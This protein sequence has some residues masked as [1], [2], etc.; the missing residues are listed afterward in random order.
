MIYIINKDVNDK[1]EFY[2]NYYVDNRDINNIKYYDEQLRLINKK[3]YHIFNIKNSVIKTEFQQDGNQVGG[4]GRKKKEESSNVPVTPTDQLFSGE[5]SDLWKLIK[6]MLRFSSIPLFV[7]NTITGKI[8]NNEILLEILMDEN[9]ILKWGEKYYSFKNIGDDDVSREKKLGEIIGQ[10]NYGAGNDQQKA[11]FAENKN[12][13]CLNF[14]CLRFARFNDKTVKQRQ[15]C[16]SCANF[17]TSNGGSSQP[18]GYQ[19]IKETERIG[20]IEIICIKA[21]ARKVMEAYT[22]MCHNNFNPEYWKGKDGIVK[23]KK[24]NNRTINEVNEL[25]DPKTGQIVDIGG[26]PY[27]FEYSKPLFKRQRRW[28]MV[29]K[30]ET[31][32]SKTNPNPKQILKQ[33]YTQWKKFVYERVKAEITVNGKPYR[34]ELRNP[35]D[36]Y[37]KG[38]IELDHKDGNHGDNVIGNINPLCRICHAI[39]TDQQQDKAGGKGE[40]FKMI[41]LFQ[42]KFDVKNRNNYLLM[43]FKNRIDH[44]KNI[45]YTIKTEEDEKGK[46]IQVIQPNYENI[47]KQFIGFKKAYNLLEEEFNKI[48]DKCL[49]IGAKFSKLKLD[50]D[51]KEVEE[52]PIWTEEQENI[53]PNLEEEILGDLVVDDEDEDEEGNEGNKGDKGD[54]EDEDDKSISTQNKIIANNLNNDNKAIRDVIEEGLPRKG[55]SRIKETE[56]ETIKAALDASAISA[57][58]ETRRRSREG[59]AKREPLPEPELTPKELAAD[60][61]PDEDPDEDED[62][63]EDPDKEAKEE[64]SN[65]LTEIT[66]YL[67]KDK[68]E[69]FL[70]QLKKEKPKLYEDL[71]N[72]KDKMIFKNSNNEYLSYNMDAEGP[73]TIKNIL[74]LRDF[75]ISKILEKITIFLNVNG[76]NNKFMKRL[77][78]K[79]NELY[80]KLR[81]GD[82]AYIFKN[83][84]TKLFFVKNM[85]GEKKREYN[86]DDFESINNI[87][88]VFETYKDSI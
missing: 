51:V 70:K 31:R 38:V 78:K 85:Y 18:F 28:G 52:D 59:R 45:Y 12:A 84:K 46:D 17:R 1:F 25:R 39:K 3:N 6:S 29:P 19:F 2:S 42:Y 36:S 83:S 82:N 57:I 66:I 15:E 81:I 54:E 86:K 60:E 64:A 73:E 14:F 9:T 23:D 61:D 21:V 74:E 4:A 63:D 50:F 40:N 24:A 79:Y 33:E 62:E 16:Q 68:E 80:L 5:Q 30:D 87:N 55:R 47:L 35:W 65:T 48:N 27:I 43:L 13:N 26:V 37:G 10:I 76:E 34:C 11:T 71:I 88:T 58:D 44:I 67:D 8:F 53:Y 69:L 77:K 22:N 41:K 75:F 56:D 49:E 20:G 7:K 72:G 32:K